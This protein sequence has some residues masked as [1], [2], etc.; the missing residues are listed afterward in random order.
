MQ[1]KKTVKTKF[2][3]IRVSDDELKEIQSIQSGY[4]KNGMSI[5]RSKILRDIL[6]NLDKV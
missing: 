5:N 2:I 4:I 3:S 6:L 1:H